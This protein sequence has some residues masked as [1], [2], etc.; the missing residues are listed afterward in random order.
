MYKLPRMGYLSG[1]NDNE[2]SQHVHTLYNESCLICTNKI[3]PVENSE[4]TAFI[5]LIGYN[6]VPKMNI[7]SLRV[8]RMRELNSNTEMLL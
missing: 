5:I 7:T 2:K 1:H 3:Y 6:F 4:Y 8:F